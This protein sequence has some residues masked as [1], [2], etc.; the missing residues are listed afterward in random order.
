MRAVFHGDKA[1]VRVR[2]RDRRGRDEGEIVEVLARNT[3]ELVGRVHFDN[4]I[5]LLESLNRASDV[6]Q[7]LPLS[8]R[9]PARGGSAVA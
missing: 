2:G 1:M 6:H 9:K 7:V 8:Q 4:R 5:A 3:L